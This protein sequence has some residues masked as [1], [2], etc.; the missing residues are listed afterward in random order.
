VTKRPTKEQE[1][2]GEAFGWGD[3][4]DVP[5]TGHTLLPEGKACF[6]ITKLE[7]Q[8]K[9]YGTFGVINVAVVTCTCFSAAD[10]ASGEADITVQLGLARSLGWKI[11]QLA[12]ACGFRKPGDGNEI[13]PRWWGK[14][15]GAEGTCTIEH[16]T[17]T[18]KKD[19][20]ERKANEI[21][22]FLPPEDGEKKDAI[23][24]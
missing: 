5:E 6:T 7:R 10:G 21:A 14:F 23:Q 11:L 18:G 17:Y 15:V 1:P 4:V 12:T 24:F 19:G 20:K 8:R 13:D 9:E 16:R 22:E 2:Q 3:A